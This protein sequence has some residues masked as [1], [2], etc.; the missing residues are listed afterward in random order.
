MARLREEVTHLQQELAYLLQLEE[1]ILM[2]LDQ[3]QATEIDTRDQLR[4]A[5][6]IVT[7]HKQAV[8][9]EQ[10]FPIFDQVGALYM[11]LADERK[12]LNIRQGL[13]RALQ[14]L[15]GGF[16]PAITANM[17]KARRERGAFVY[18][19]AAGFVGPA[20]LSRR[21]PPRG[22]LSREIEPGF[23]RLRPCRTPRTPVTGPWRQRWSTWR[24]QGPR[25]HGRTRRARRLPSSPRS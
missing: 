23:D 20:A 2:G 19:R 11:S 9:K 18:R 21:V 7:E 1:D 4:S 10:V 14:A 25:P 15:I 3:V 16:K 13:L 17:F 12:M 22:K 5:H 6:Q 24:G 8:P